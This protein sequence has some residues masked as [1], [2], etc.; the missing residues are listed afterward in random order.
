M[1]NLGGFNIVRPF[2]IYVRLTSWVRVGAGH[3]TRTRCATGRATTSWAGLWAWPRDFTIITKIEKNS[4]VSQERIYFIEQLLKEIYSTH[5]HTLTNILLF[6]WS[7][8]WQQHVILRQEETIISINWCSQPGIV[9]V[10]SRIGATFIRFVCFHFYRSVFFLHFCF[11]MA[12]RLMWTYV[13]RFDSRVFRL[14]RR[15]F[16]LDSWW[17][18]LHFWFLQYQWPNTS[19]L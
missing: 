1:T 2:N 16:R 5:T 4:F 9:R 6:L 18:G 8:N 10:G 13:F 7:S 17:L 19:L 11:P 15:I 3:A 14:H 12:G